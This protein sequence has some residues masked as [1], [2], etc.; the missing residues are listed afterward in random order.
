MDPDEEK[1]EQTT[2]ITSAELEEKIGTAVEAK[3]EPLMN[4]FTETLEESLKALQ[5]TKTEPEGEEKEPGEVTAT[6][7]DVK[8]EARC[9]Y[10][11]FGEFLK[12]VQTCSPGSGNSLTNRM[13]AVMKA[14]SG[15]GENVGSD[16]GFLIPADF[17]TA[18]WQRVIDTPENLVNRTDQYAISG[19]R[20]VLPTL[21]E[22]SRA[23][24]ARAGGIV[25]TWLD[26]GTTKP[27]SQPELGR[28]ELNLHKLA[29]VVVATDELLDDSAVALESFIT[30]VAGDEIAFMLNNSLIRGTGVGMPMGILNA[31]CLVT[32]AAE[33]GQPI[34]TIVAENIS[35]MW[36]RMYAPSRRNA[37]WL[38]NQDIEPELD[39]MTIN[40]GTGGLPVYLPA[41]GYSVSPYSTLKG[42]PVIPVE[43][44]STLG[45][46]GDIILADW[47]QY[48]TI[49]KTSGIEAAVSMHIRFLF[50]EQTFRFVMRV[51]GQPWW[52]TD[53]T[54]Y[55]G[56]GNTLSPFVTLAP[57]P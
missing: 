48:I 27:P 4:R 32:V 34:T 49:T 46:L 24:G 19:N 39:N 35:N 31:P 41:G 8:A 15:M 43:W 50:D 3:M 40:V 10:K 7:H 5:V 38:I 44:C 28:L 52:A 33:A 45:V 1:K 25:G 16:G 21:A 18:I 9:G 12:D 29:I 47:S 13:A 22:T 56:V 53:L 17:V 6:A 11:A 26:E 57:R 36:A 2:K 42:R 51:D 55:Q 30:K 37:V 23:D 14:A 54:P 20:M